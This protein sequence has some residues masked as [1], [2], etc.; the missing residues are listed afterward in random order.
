MDACDNIPNFGPA[1]GLLL[2]GLSRG[3][4]YALGREPC[5]LL[6]GGVAF[7]DNSVSHAPVTIAATAVAM[8]ESSLFIESF[9][10]RPPRQFGSF[11]RKGWNVSMT[12]HRKASTARLHSVAVDK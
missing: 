5:S 3:V 9:C 2:L 8:D 4:D 12:S 6:G 10:D 1:Q 7:M 11:D